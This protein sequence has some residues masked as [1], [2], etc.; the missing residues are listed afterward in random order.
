[1]FDFFRAALMPFLVFGGILLSYGQEEAQIA[2]YNS[3]DSNVGIENTDLYQGII[4][5]E[6]Y[7]TINEKTQFFQTR[8]FQ[9]GSVCYDGQCYYNLD[10]KYDV[11]EDEVLIRLITRVG[12]GTLKLVKDYV[13]SFQIDGH[14][15]VKI[16]PK[17]TPSLASYGFY[18]VT[19][20]S[21][22]FTLFIKHTKKSFDRKDRKSL[23]YEFLEGQGENV[24][25]YKGMYT[26][27]N[28]KKD[29]VNLFP[30]LKR[31]IDKFYNVARGL[32]KSNPDGFRISLIKRIEILL[33]QTTN[34]S[35]K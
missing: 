26:V 10:L 28:S 35:E 3:F 9:S 34:Q 6:K 29:V 13:E 30:N 1:M 17:D 5:T 19:H 31:E 22:T 21:A 15:F 8:E 12:G 25:L 20:E 11:Y 14:N 32:R 16:L 33:S 4:Y 18:E 2:Y 24:L 23:Y 27:I 7:R